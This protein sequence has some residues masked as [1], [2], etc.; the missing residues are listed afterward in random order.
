M[1]I[2]DWRF[3]LVTGNPHPKWGG[4]IFAK[5]KTNCIIMSN[6]NTILTLDERMR[7]DFGERLQGLPIAAAVDLSPVANM[8][9]SGTTAGFSTLGLPGYFCGDRDADT[10]V[11]NL[12]PGIDAGKSDSQ[13]SSD[14]ASF[15][16]ISV[17]SFIDDYSISCR[18]YGINDKA[19]YDEFDI[20]QAAFWLPWSNS[21]IRFQR[22]L[23]WKNRGDCLK[24]KESVLTDKLQLELVAYASSK[25]DINKK[26]IHL[27]YPFIQTLLV[28][29]FS[30]ERTYVVFASKIFE[31]I[32]KAYN[33]VYPNTFD[34]L[35]EPYCITKLTKI[36]GS[37]TRK[38]FKCKVITIHLNGKTQKAM[39]ARSFP[40]QDIS[41]AFITMQQYGQFCYDVWKNSPF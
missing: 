30:K 29:I 10:V 34:G 25:F 23:D 33:R 1:H 21:G 35:S 13:W 15:N 14:T 20:K 27:F 41:K 24:A 2:F 38:S 37:P 17:N 39:I 3:R 32:F 7:Q 18:D 26:Q 16:K 12:N 9:N 19:R 6:A 40:S 5:N 22:P 36:D 8:R 4:M 28:E 31:D 11:V